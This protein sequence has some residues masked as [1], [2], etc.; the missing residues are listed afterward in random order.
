MA[1]NSELKCDADVAPPSLLNGSKSQISIIHLQTKS[2]KN[3]LLKKKNPQS[4]RQRERRKQRLHEA[5]SRQ[6]LG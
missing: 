6:A 3:K 1:E 5:F 2:P 4:E